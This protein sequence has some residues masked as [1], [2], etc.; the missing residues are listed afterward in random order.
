MSVCVLCGSVRV[1]YVGVSVLRINALYSYV[2]KIICRRKKSL[3]VPHSSSALHA[4][5]ASSKM[6]TWPKIGNTNWPTDIIDCQS[7]KNDITNRVSDWF[8]HQSLRTQ[9]RHDLKNAPHPQAQTPKKRRGVLKK[10]RGRLTD[11]ILAR[12]Y[13]DNIIQWALV[14]YLTYADFEFSLSAERFW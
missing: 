1:F 2:H 14:I 12:N 11:D 3:D 13:W 5:R 6:V 7:N 10:R 9:P 8:D 4:M